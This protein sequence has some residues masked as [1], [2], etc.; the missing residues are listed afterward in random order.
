MGQAVGR[1][2]GHQDVV[3]GG[4]AAAINA[5]EIDAAADVMRAR[6]SLVGHNRF[7]ARQRGLPGGGP[8]P[9]QVAAGILRITLVELS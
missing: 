8:S 6:E 1:G 3:G 7:A 5:L 4:A 2:E 9:P